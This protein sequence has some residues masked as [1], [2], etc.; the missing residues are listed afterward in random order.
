MNRKQKRAFGRGTVYFRHGAKSEPGN[1]NDLRRVIERE[2]EKI[3]KSWLGNIRRVVRAPV[4]SHVQVLPPRVVESD[5]PNAVPI[6]VVEDPNAPA[7]RK[8]DYDHTHP[9][10]QK[11]IIELVNQR[12][13]NK[14]TVN[15]YDI[16]SVRKVHKIHEKPEYYHKPKYSTPQYSEDF[17]DWLVKQYERD[18]SF[19][20]MARQKYRQLMDNL[21]RMRENTREDENT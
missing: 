21:K 6:R 1:S 20:E 16:L 8:V 11:K 17:V 9:Y 14:K 7:Y 19:F 15:S 10:R 4:G 2:L 18:P 13:G 12:L 5:L 3:R